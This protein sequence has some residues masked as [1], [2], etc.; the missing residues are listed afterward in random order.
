MIQLR[1]LLKED[2]KS[3][4]TPKV[5]YNFYALWYA[6]LHHPE[7]RSDYGKEV[8]EYYTTKYKAL[9]VNLFNQL[10]KEQLAK[11]ISLNRLD[12]DFPTKINVNTLTPL[13]LKTLMNKTFRTD[14]IRRNDVWNLIADYNNSL[15]TATD[16][17]TIFLMIDRLNNA[18]HNTKTSVLDKLPHYHLELKKALDACHNLTNVNYLKTYVDKDI[19]SLL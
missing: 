1:K 9:Y 10:L 16:S 2:I 19:R 6:Y 14:R 7:A 5:I 17:K 15:S 13:Q 12:P 8:V 11:Y 4:L 18:V 3:E